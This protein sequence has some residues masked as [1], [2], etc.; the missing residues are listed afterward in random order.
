MWFSQATKVSD[1]LNVVFIIILGLI[2]DLTHFLLLNSVTKFSISQYFSIKSSDFIHNV[3]ASCHFSFS[4]LSELNQIIV[5]SFIASI[6]VCTVTI[7]L[8]RI[9]TFT[10]LKLLSYFVGLLINNDFT[11]DD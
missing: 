11:N 5:T 4:G 8:H 10:F 1:S 7:Q 9:S 2:L 6:G 3:I